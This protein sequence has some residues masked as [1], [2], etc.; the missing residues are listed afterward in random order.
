MGAPKVRPKIPSPS[1]STWSDTKPRLPGRWQRIR[2]S[3]WYAVAG[4]IG[5]WSLG[6]FGGAA[7][8]LGAG[9]GARIATAVVGVT[10]N[11]SVAR[12]AGSGAA[13]AFS[14]GFLVGQ[15]LN[16]L[17][18][19]GKTS[20][21]RMIGQ[22]TAQ[23]ATQRTARELGQAS[24]K[25]SMWTLRQDSAQWYFQRSQQNLKDMLDIIDILENIRGGGGLPGL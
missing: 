12:Q 21:A 23:E 7:G 18:P 11:V 3:L 17:I 22:Q 19:P 20:T 9:I 2:K 16:R 10:M 25:R 15:S 5:G 13:G 1:T 24:F 6:G 4:A 8:S 14:F